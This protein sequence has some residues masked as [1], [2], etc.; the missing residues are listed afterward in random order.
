MTLCA[1]SQVEHR[2]YAVPG[3][4][5]S[6]TASQGLDLH[7]CARR[8]SGSDSRREYSR[9]WKSTDGRFSSASSPPTPFQEPPLRGER[10]MTIAPIQAIRLE[11]AVGSRSR[12]HI[13]D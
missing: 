10:V 9:C 1:A 6:M 8:T 13:G 3:V 2:L 5:I 4:S 12:L 7:R 11:L